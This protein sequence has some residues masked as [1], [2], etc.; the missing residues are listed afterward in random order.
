MKILYVIPARGGSKGIPKKNIKP[1]NG[2]P[3]IYYTIDVARQL[4]TDNNICVST[5]DNEI[6]EVVEDYG[7]KVPFKRPTHLATDTATSNDVLLHA[8]SYYENKGEHYDVLVLLQPTSPLRKAA[9]VKEALSLYD[10]SLDMVVSVKESHSASVICSENESGFLEL[11]LN[12]M[13][14]R[15]QNISSFYEYNGAIYIINLKSLKERPLFQLTKIKKYVM[16]EVSS[17]DI[18]DQLDWQLAEII[19]RQ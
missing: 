10:E 3:L 15:R 16:D 11:T 18:D 19:G 13:G 2:K 4:T 5:D 17:H 7:L 14:L 12:K 9:Q 1:L 8:V 6:I